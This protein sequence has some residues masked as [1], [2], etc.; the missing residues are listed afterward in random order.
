M[1]RERK[2]VTMTNCYVD[3]VA[4]VDANGADTD[5]VVRYYIDGL[6][7]TGTQVGNI[8][9]DQGLDRFVLGYGAD[10]DVVIDTSGNVGINE[11]TPA[12]KLD[13]AGTAAFGDTDGTDYADF[14]ADG[15]LNLHGTARVLKYSWLPAGAV[16]GVGANPASEA[17]NA[18]GFVILEFAD[19]ADDY[20]QFN[21]RIP[22]D[23]DLSAD[24][25]L[26]VGWSVP[27]LSANMDWGYGYL[28]TA[29]NDDTEGAATTGTTTVT[30][31]GTADG[32]NVDVVFTIAGG[33]L[34]ASDFCLHVYIYR[35][36]SADTYGNPVDLHGVALR[37]TA[38]KLGTA[39]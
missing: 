38:N 37:Y 28:V 10:T 4:D 14:A 8:G 19:A 15:E 25:S 31:S 5:A 24:I 2:F 11:D 27:N 26:C 1:S 16:R 36:V 13:V 33:T 3:V 29:E 30:S 32:L 21:T 20:A 39:T 17:L 9:Y 23:A 6:P 35:D 34:A 22:E 18:S 12:Y 7:G